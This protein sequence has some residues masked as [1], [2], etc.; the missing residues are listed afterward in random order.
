VLLLC[1][2]LLAA[3]QVVV[4]T[5]G[6]PVPDLVI[7]SLGALLPLAVATRIVDAPGAAS[8]ACGAYLLPRTLLS[9]M[10][11]SLEPP[12]LLLVP[13]LVFDLSL[14]ARSADLAR[15]K[16][17]WP[18][19]QSMWRRR[20]PKVNR[21]RTPL[22]AA[23]AGGLFGLTAAGLQPTYAVL[24]GADASIWSGTLLWLAVALSVAACAGLSAVVSGRGT[25]S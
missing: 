18:R 8:A 16:S 17:V 4:G 24:L 14:W 11:P 10:E 7:L 2:V 15:L 1:A 6:R 13:A 5:P 20:P 3:I 12:P 19:R 22:R 9:L 21:I 23:I 25:G